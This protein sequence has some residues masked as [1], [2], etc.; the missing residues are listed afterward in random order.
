MLK[1]LLRN[2]EV[3][4]TLEPGHLLVKLSWNGSVL[5]EYRWPIPLVDVNVERWVARRKVRYSGQTPS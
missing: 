2:V 1:F 3:E 5:F 4:V